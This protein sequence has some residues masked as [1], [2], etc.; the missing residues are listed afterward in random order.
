MNLMRIHA[1]RHITV[2]CL[3]AMLISAS[4]IQGRAE[5]CTPTSPD[6]LGPFYEPDAPVRPSVGKGYILSGVVR[7]S[8]DCKPLQGARIEFWLAGTDGYYDDDHRATVISGIDG[9]YKFESNQPKP[10]AGR[11]PHI[12]IRVSSEGFQVLVTQHYPQKGKTGDTFDLVLV[13]VK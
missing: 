8:A 9:G 4:A 12:H 3:T 11:P 6:M 7:S 2:M 1:F 5:T 10:Y 13:P